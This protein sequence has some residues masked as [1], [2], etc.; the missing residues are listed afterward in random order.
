MHSFEYHCPTEIIFGSGAENHVAEKIR[1]Y[2]GTRVMILYG[3]GSAVKSGLVPKIEKLLSDGGL[4]LKTLG[5]VKPN[6]RLSFAR[7]AVREAI[8]AKIN[9]VLAV[10]GGSVIDTAKAIALGAANPDADIW[11]HWTKKITLEKNLPV[12]VVLTIAA[13]GS[14]TSDS[15]VLTNEDTGKKM[16]TITP[17]PAF[18]I[19]NPEF[20]LTVPHYP[21]I[22]GIADIIMHTL[23]RYFSKIE[24]NEFTD[25]V[26]E[27][28]IKNVIES[29]RFARH[30]RDNV[31]RVGFAHGLYGAWT[32]KRFFRAQT[33][34]RTQWT[35]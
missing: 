14:E 16:G 19:M 24:G 7:Q 35:L 33:W 10:G 34:S 27:S 6:P 15:A 23:E 22:C 29:A 1:K 25:M 30:E 2:G 12:G 32:R 17:R 9:F 26:A 11:D 21:M 20:A 3:G 28:L 5:G 31:V 18:A 4:E 13:A 8:D